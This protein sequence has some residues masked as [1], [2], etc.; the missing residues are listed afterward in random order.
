[1]GSGYEFHFLIIQIYFIEG[2]A[3]IHSLVSEHQ[4]TVLDA[5]EGHCLQ[6]D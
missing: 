1:M 4:L 2:L 6:S 3:S 5:V